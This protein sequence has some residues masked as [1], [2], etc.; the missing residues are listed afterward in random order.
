MSDDYYYL[1]QSGHANNNSKDRNRMNVGGAEL[2]GDKGV[3]KMN[4]QMSVGLDSDQVV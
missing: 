4:N 3:R 1:Y 2:G